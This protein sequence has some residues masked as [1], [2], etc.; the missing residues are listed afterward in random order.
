[1]SHHVSV[2]QHFKLF[3]GGHFVQY[4]QF[5]LTSLQTT[6]FRQRI[7]HRTVVNEGCLEHGEQGMHFIFGC[8]IHTGAV[9]AYIPTMDRVNLG[10][11]VCPTFN[12]C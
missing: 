5:L 4:L 7:V 12:G 1:M 6:H 10:I 8:S 3:P 9:I 2:H 11:F